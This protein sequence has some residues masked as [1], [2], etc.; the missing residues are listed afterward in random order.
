MENI[1]LA[2][3]GVFITF[4]IM[5]AQSIV[6]IK[7]SAEFYKPE[8]YARLHRHIKFMTDLLRIGVFNTVLALAV[9][10][11]I[12]LET[13]YK[14]EILQH[15]KTIYWIHLFYFM[16]ILTTYYVRANKIFDDLN[17]Y[18]IDRQRE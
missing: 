7:S 18:F 13:Q 6:G 15:I 8:V 16:C 12:S 3:N 2:L 17:L 14:N 5:A 1:L 10:T 4:S 9:I 11:I